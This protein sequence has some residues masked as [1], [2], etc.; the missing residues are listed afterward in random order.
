MGLSAWT[1]KIIML[2]AVVTAVTVIITAITKIIKSFGGFKKRELEKEK[3]RM[4]NILDELMPE[5]F[6]QHDKQTRDKYL[7]DRQR[8]L[9]EISTEVLQHTEKDLKI[10]KTLTEDQ[11]KIIDLLRRNTL[12]VLRQKIENIYY[13]YRSQKAMPMYVLENLEELYNDYKEGGGNHH[14]GTL[15]DRMKKWEIYDEIPEYEKE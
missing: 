2:A 3:E 10:I 5:Y 4:K 7:A 9:Q 15:Y 13:Q 8:Y 14:I 12:D 11:S 1:D 6:L